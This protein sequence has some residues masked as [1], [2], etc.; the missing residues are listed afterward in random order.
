MP[1]RKELAVARLHRRERVI[2]NLLAGLDYRE[3]A[4]HLKI[5]L[6]TVA[7]DVS[8]LLKEWQAA[9]VKTFDDWQRLQ[10]KRTDRM[11][12]AIWKKVEDGDLLAIDRALAIMEK[13]MKL[14]G[15]EKMA[16]FM[17]LNIDVENL[18]DDLID[19]LARGEQVDFATL[20]RASRADKAQEG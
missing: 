13:Q 2:A 7:N 5:S 8:A 14:L 6:G 15:Y 19:K 17:A 9:N 4:E 18:P 16:A 10:L 3:I 11:I 20:T 1:T 12:N